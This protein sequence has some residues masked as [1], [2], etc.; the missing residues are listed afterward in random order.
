MIASYGIKEANRVEKHLITLNKRVQSKLEGST[1]SRY[2]TLGEVTLDL[3]PKAPIG[4]IAWVGFTLVNWSLS[5]HFSLRKTNSRSEVKS[6]GLQKCLQRL[7]REI[8]LEHM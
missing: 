4:E 8:I 3:S 6:T 1:D 7:H 2:K 5:W